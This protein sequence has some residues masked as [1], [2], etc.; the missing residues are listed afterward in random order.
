VATEIVVQ[1]VTYDPQKDM[2]YLAIHPD[3]PSITRGNRHG[4]LVMYDEADRQTLVGIEVMD[5]ATYL[6]PLL[7]K[8]GVV[9]DLFERFT[10]ADTD[11]QDA[12][13]RAVFEWCYRQ[14]VLGLLRVGVA[15]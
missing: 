8:S 10:V 12:D 6:V 1:S 13:L 5:F 15:A 14:H 9:P 7:Y 3:R 4:V 2:L 11:L